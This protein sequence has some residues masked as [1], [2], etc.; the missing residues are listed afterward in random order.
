MSA[1]SSPAWSPALSSPPLSAE[2]SVPSISGR[3]SEAEVYR[4]AEVRLPGKTAEPILPMT[5][6]ST[7][8]PL[9]RLDSSRKSSGSIITMTMR[10][11]SIRKWTAFIRGF[12]NHWMIRTRNTIRQTRPSSS[13]RRRKASITA[14]ARMSQPTKIPDTRCFREFS[15]ILRRKRQGF[16]TAISSQ[17]STGRMS[18]ACR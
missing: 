18:R 12:L 11:R 6:C 4:R 15:R 3:R 9:R 13:P 2:R 1:A 10:S 5:Q 8:N 16:R 17:R 7:R 14:S